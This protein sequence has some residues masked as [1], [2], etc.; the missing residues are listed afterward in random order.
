MIFDTLTLA[1]VLLML[2]YIVL[3]VAF[4]RRKDTAKPAAMFVFND[5]EDEVYAYG[6][7]R[8]TSVQPTSGP[9]NA[10]V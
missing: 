2:L 10:S 3:L 6:V 5:T 7:R 9:C 4:N 1:G 8:K